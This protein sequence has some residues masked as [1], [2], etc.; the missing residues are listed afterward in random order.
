MCPHCSSP[1]SCWLIRKS[2][3]L[4]FLFLQGLKT[5]GTA[6]AHKPCIFSLLCILCILYSF[7]IIS[8]YGLATCS[9]EYGLWQLLISTQWGVWSLVRYKTTW[10][11]LW[12][13]WIASVWFGWLCQGFGTQIRGCGRWSILVVVDQSGT[14]SLASKFWPAK[15]LTSLGLPPC[16]MKTV[17]H[18]YVTRERQWFF[19]SDL[20]N[21][22]SSFPTCVL[23]DSDYSLC[24][25]S[26]NLLT[27]VLLNVPFL[28]TSYCSPSSQ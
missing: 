6:S 9:L 23:W 22:D 18:S 1:R 8:I 21:P 4:F 20:L 15:H 26:L 3:L 14:V 2:C 17:F 19:S 7:S 5:W 12:D 16:P 10:S 27:R 25:C 24:H 28:L 13:V 11:W